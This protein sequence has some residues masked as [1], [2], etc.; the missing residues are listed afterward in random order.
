MLN[1]KGGHSVKKVTKKGGWEPS[2]SKNQTNCGQFSS[3]IQIW[4]HFGQNFVINKIEIVL[5]SHSC[6][7]YH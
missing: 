5:P 1:E 6:H 4:T 7:Y 2:N 3:K